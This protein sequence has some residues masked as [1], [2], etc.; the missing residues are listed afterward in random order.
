MTRRLVQL[1]DRP[2]TL[3]LSWG[4]PDPS[5]PASDAWASAPPAP[6]RAARL[7]RTLVVPMMR[8][9]LDGAWAA[10]QGADEPVVVPVVV[11]AVNTVNA[12]R[13]DAARDRPSSAS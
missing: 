11:E 2:G 13:Q 9:T 10:A 12:R 6:L 1:V 8:A 5:L 4:Q 3:A 7:W